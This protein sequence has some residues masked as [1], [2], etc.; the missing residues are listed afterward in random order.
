MV[1]PPAAAS[2]PAASR[3]EL[4]AELDQ[5]LSDAA[6]GKGQGLLLSGAG[7]SGKS[8]LLR[9]AVQR[10]RAKGFRVLSGRAL[11]E[12]LPS[13]FS[14][15]RDLVRSVEDLH[16]STPTHE[17]ETLPIFLAP[18][19]ESAGA[20]AGAPRP[21]DGESEEFEAL[22]GLLTP[23]AS[24]SPEGHVAGREELLLR[25]GEYFLGLAKERPLTVAIDD[26]HFADDSS[27]AFLRAFARELPRGPVVL[28]A[29]A[30]E[31]AEVPA[32]AYPSIQALGRA[33]GVRARAVPPLSVA[34]VGELVKAILG[35]RDPDP[36]DVR[37]WHAQTEGNPLLVEQVVRTA[38]GFGP[39]P[40]A[41]DRNLGEVFADRVRGLAEPD[42]RL[43]TYA[44]VLGKE[45]AFARLVTV[46]GE[47]EERVTESLD[48]LVR[49]GLVREKGGE[50]YEFV[51]EAV[52]AG[53]YAELTETRRRLLHR[54]AG[55]ALEAHGGA[56]D[57]ELARHYYLGRD[58]AK[59][60][61]YNWR[62][63]QR[64]A[65]AFAF[66]TALSHVARALEAERRRPDR[67]ARGEVRLLTEEGRLLEEIGELSRSQASLDEAVRLAREKPGFDLELGRA[68]LGLAQTRATSGDYAAAALVAT[69][70]SELLE[71]VG[72]ARD[73]LSA[74]RVLGTVSWRLGELADAE[75]HQRTALDLAEREGSPL[76]Q[77]HALVDLGNTLVPLGSA[78]FD[79]A[80]EYYTR[81][82]TLFA[83]VEDH[84]AQA[85]VL[86]NRAVLEYGAARVDDAFRDLET[87]IVAAERSRSP[88]WIGYCYLNLAQWNAEVGRTAAA[89]T[90]LDRAVQVI[91]PLGDRL[92]LQQAEMAEGMIREA[93][94]EFDGAESHYQ[95]ALLRARDLGT[96][97][98]L[99]EMLYRLAHLADARGDT[100]L[101]RSRLGEAIA[102]G[103]KDHR[104]D[105]ASRVEELEKR[106]AS[107]A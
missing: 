62:A 1:G 50:V 17:R 100:A 20:P 51:T 101:A 31:G 38:T 80:L 68:L 32:R 66:D 67:D 60:I 37:R 36:R 70:A 10:A 26:L 23:L 25:L 4:L 103:L 65:R 24:V 82:A 106:L 75:R 39:A 8:F 85:R 55:R 35:G 57:V 7:G 9:S 96:P 47:G 30:A 12:E 56:S 69:E 52:R 44:A 22:E 87:A 93:D 105:L 92:A 34:E 6:R 58:Y 2:P 53:V 13:P 14:L 61:E 41:P 104:P 86:M 48:R 46:A 54:K 90:A 27:L 19:G 99:A 98:E 89:R 63:A 18:F 42:R 45:F 40:E 21:G 43:L 91:H 15:V 107:A 16:R 97:V 102:S 78:R 74:H 71:R 95:E 76:E 83:G 84:S 33:E 28:L 29:T 79:Q 49:G 88:I 64:A 94:R 77:G 73:L 81:A 3:V 5:L 11:P 59:A 72:G